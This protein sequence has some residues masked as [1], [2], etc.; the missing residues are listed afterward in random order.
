MLAVKQEIRSHLAAITKRWGELT[1]PAQFELRCLEQDNKLPSWQHFAPEQIDEAVDYAASQNASNNNVYV[2]VNPI[3]IERAGK[4]S[5]TADVIAAFYA[6]ADADDQRGMDNI[7][8]FAGPQPS[9]TVKT[10]STPHLRGH[11]YW[12]LDEPVYNLSAWTE[13]QKA[14]LGSLQT[15][16]AIHN[17][18]RIMRLAGTVTW[19][20][21]KKRGRG[22]VPEISTIKTV[23]HT[24]RD[25]VEFQ[26]MYQ[27]FQASKSD[28]ISGFASAGIDLGPQR[29]DRE[30]ARIKALSGE[31]WNS[32]V[33]KL[34]GSYVTKGLDDDE[35]QSLVEELTFKT[36]ASRR[37]IQKM[38]DG[39]RAKGYAP[40]EPPQPLTTEELSALPELP[41]QS[42]IEKD[43]AAIPQPQFVYS[44]FYATGYTSLT[45]AP[46]KV[47][48]SML[49]LAEAIDIATGRGILTGYQR[50]PAR[51]LYYNAEDDQDVL[52]SRV[53]A[54][55]TQYQIDQAEI[56][57]RLY[58]VSGIDHDDFW[59]IGGIEG[60]INETLFAQLETFITVNKIDVVIFDPLQDLSRS[61]ETNEIFRSVGQRLR[62]MANRTQTA[63]GL[64]HHTRKIA[65]GVTASIDDARGGSA[66]RGTSRF[67]RILVSM[68]EDEGAKAGITNHRYYFRLA[69]MESNLAPPSATVNQWYEKVSVM[70]PS[71]QSVGAVKKWQW[72]D[73]FDGVTNEDAAAV[74]QAVAAMVSNEPSQSSQA[75]NWVG[76]TVAIALQLDV[77]QD[78]VKA[79][80]KELV[81]HWIRT[82]VL[83]IEERPDGR[84]GRIKKVVVA[85]MNSP[86]TTI[87]T[88]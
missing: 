60:V 59:L 78:A 63:L 35:I 72:P 25:P 2:T 81:K 46:P 16:P 77:S 20:D 62:L 32:H 54:L 65:Q 51:V 88:H 82:D 70:L 6:F 9:L 58:A 8:S 80:V 64:V 17:P 1:E 85:G 30:K 73:A 44:D 29:L 84:N 37:Q 86:T 22:Y 21:E 12:E 42:W 48:K 83:A 52:N 49:A 19:P 47:G 5:S 56:V 11:A 55:L 71:G 57:G 53:A 74:Q 79:R 43:L 3:R 45:V 87:T 13:L 27:V 41:F 18:D 15:D 10:G 36:E 34:V 69:D 23:F 67:N 40:S 68:S 76:V 26:R 7:R 4:A 38:I 61:P 50:E 66:L 28:P 31:E 39:A 75:A 24:D 14:I 33:L